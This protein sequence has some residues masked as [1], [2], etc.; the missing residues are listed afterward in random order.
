M[1]LADYFNPDRHYHNIEHIAELLIRL[2]PMVDEYRP[3]IT[4]LEELIQA[5]IWHDETYVPLKSGNERMSARSAVRANPLLNGEVLTRIIMATLH[6]GGPLETI[7]EQIMADI[8]LRGFAN[9]LDS[10]LQTDASVRQEFS[11]VSD[12]D[13]K[14]GRGNFFRRLLE[15]PRIYYT[16]LYFR[17][18]EKK[19][20]HNLQSALTALYM[21]EIM[22]YECP[23]CFTEIL[24]PPPS[25]TNC[26]MCN[27]DL[28]PM[29]ANIGDSWKL[30]CS[31]KKET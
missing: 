29:A 9:D 4:H 17:Q 22:I 19:A 28:R 20:R 25:W 16:D 27:Q 21:A 2:R 13:W 15:R 24:G 3:Q 12:E 31:P 1:S 18:Y 7:E 23:R 5:V 6:E 26:P 30:L 14:T 10:F 8:D 11:Q